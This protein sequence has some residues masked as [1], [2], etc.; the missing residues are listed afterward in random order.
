MLPPPAYSL[1]PPENENIP[2]REF[3]PTYDQIIRAKRFFFVKYLPGCSRFA[4]PSSRA[5][6][7]TEL[8]AIGVHIGHPPVRRSVGQAC[9]AALKGDLTWMLALILGLAFLLGF[10]LKTYA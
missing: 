1:I 6:S 5:L 8:A 9:A 3:P 2:F 4:C 10:L 7:P